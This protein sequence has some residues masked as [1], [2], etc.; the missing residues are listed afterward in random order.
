MGDVGPLFE[1]EQEQRNEGS[2]PIDNTV[3]QKQPGIGQS[4]HRSARGVHRMEGPEPSVT[5]EQ[6]M[7]PG[8]RQV[9]SDRA[10]KDLKRSWLRSNAPLARLPQLGDFGGEVFDIWA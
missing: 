3:H 8:L 9:G 7:H 6:S 10:F 4:V 5:A 1:T 2:R